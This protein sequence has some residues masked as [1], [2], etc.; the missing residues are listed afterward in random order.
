MNLLADESVAAGIVDRLRLDGHRVDYVAEMSPS[1]TDD[2]VLGHV[3][4]RQCPLVTGD[5]DFGELV[6]RLRRV[7]HGVILLRLSGLAP[8]LK[9]SVVS[10][11]V[12]LH[13]SEMLHAFVVISPGLVRIRRDT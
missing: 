13:G 7:S 1:I 8:Q 12:R 6:Y 10:E 2:D 4:A 3:N 11:A 9:A 5:K